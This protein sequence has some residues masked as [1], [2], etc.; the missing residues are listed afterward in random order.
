MARDAPFIRSRAMTMKSMGMFLGALLLALCFGG[1]KRDAPG[2]A[3]GD[4]GL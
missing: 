2:G 3:A 1:C 4:H